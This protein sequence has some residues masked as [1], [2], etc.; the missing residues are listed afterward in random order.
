M[1]ILSGV[2]QRALGIIT[3]PRAT[4]E[5]VTKSPR[6]LAILVLTSLVTAAAGAIVLETDIGQLALLDQW[7]RT[8]SAFGRPLSDAEYTAL[9]GASGNGAGYA[10]MIALASG[11]ILV[12]ALSAVL[13]FAFRGAAPGTVTFRQV[14]AVVAHAGVIL[15][16]RQ[17]VA[18]PVTY[19]SETLTSPITLGMFFRMLNE[20]SPLARFFNII[21]LF[22]VWWV[23][24]LAIG[25]SV[26]YRRPAR[27]LAGVF[28]GAY[29]TLAIALTVAMA[30]TGG[31]A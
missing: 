18:A 13:F 30:A 3:H 6:W 19:V 20:A 8:A 7:E 17:L 26:L 1:A 23:F 24:V 9:A 14:L 11:P 10:A 22:V 27:R 2:G 4:F 15:A 12:I 28:V 21:D 16:L 31:T 29:V 5:A 25:M